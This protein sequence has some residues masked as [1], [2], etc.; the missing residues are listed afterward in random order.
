MISWQIA[1]KNL[2]LPIKDMPTKKDEKN[3]RAK[4]SSTAYLKKDI[5]IKR[6]A[7]RAE[8]KSNII[9]NYSIE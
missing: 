8:T 6:L 5:E 1:A 3:L 7:N 9:P 4:K 2:F